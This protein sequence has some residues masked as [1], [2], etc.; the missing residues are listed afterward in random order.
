MFCQKCG[1]EVEDEWVICPYCN[2]KLD[3]EVDVDTTKSQKS[4]KNE[5]KTKG[6]KPLWKKWW[7][8]LIA[9]IV[10]VV[11][12][13]FA[14]GGEDSDSIDEREES[15]VVKS[16]DEVG[17]YKE[18]A[19]SGYE[20]K[21][22]TD[23]VVDLPVTDRKEN[24][25]CVH[26]MTSV[27][28]PIFITQQDEKPASEWAWLQ[29]ATP[30]IDGG[31]TATFKA[32][33]QLSGYVEMDGEIIPEFCVEDIESYGVDESS[34]IEDSESA[35]NETDMITLPITVVNNTGVDIYSFYASIS[36]S[37]NWEEDILD[38]QIL[39]DGE[40]IIINFTFD[41]EQLIWDFAMTDA[42]DT[43]IEFYGLD[44]SDCKMSGATLTLMYDG[45][46]GYATLR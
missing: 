44:F 43:M 1:K 45:E 6:K 39:Y 23:I 2:A 14:G 41:S 42:E 25:Y 18:W 10:V 32:T 21:V 17:G 22:R 24:N 35:D 27:G 9:I 13:M 46:D 40:S 33:L 37:D 38:D 16:M 30:D 5:N 7:F 8:W 29:N 20:G 15:S 36:D 28:D 11:I 34:T 19:D 4:K 3:K 26:I 31:D 12:L